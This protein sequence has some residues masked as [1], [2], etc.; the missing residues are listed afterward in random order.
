MDQAVTSKHSNGEIILND[1]ERLAE[2]HGDLLPDLD[3]SMWDMFHSTAIKYPYR[4]A[5]VS[6]WQPITHLSNLVGTENGPNIEVEK[7]NEAESVFRWNYEEL[8]RAVE[9]L[10]GWLE[11]KECAEGQ[12]LVSLFGSEPSM[13]LI[14]LA[15][16]ICLEFSG[17]G[18]LLLGI[19]TNED[20]FHSSRST[21]YGARCP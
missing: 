16:S 10:A 3:H 9:L 21:Q 20:D 1:S 19:G 13:E 8:L 12:N 6:L 2:C 18:S 11:G 7:L 15:G 14:S 17:M 5:I 4:D